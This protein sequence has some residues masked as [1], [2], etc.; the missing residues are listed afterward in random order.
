LNLLAVFFLAGW[1][2]A[3]QGNPVQSSDANQ[4]DSA[5]GTRKVTLQG[6]LAKSGSD[7]F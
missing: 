2:I 5:Q 7:S 1:L 3:Q 4:N 6:C